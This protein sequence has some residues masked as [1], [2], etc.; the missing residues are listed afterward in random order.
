[1]R[2]GDVLMLAAG[3]VVCLVAGLA[4]GYWLGRNAATGPSFPG[5]VDQPV[6]AT[7]PRADEVKW[8]REVADQYLQA[9]GQKGLYS[10]AASAWT[11]Q[12]F[13]DRLAKSDLQDYWFTGWHIDEEKPSP[14]GDEVVFSGALKATWAASSRAP[15]ANQLASPLDLAFTVRVVKDRQS[16][17]WL[18]DWAQF[19]NGKSGDK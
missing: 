5:G 7:A 12:A 10:A 6:P 18:V 15:L 16:G 13:R 11:S 2:Q 3:V 9:A 1:M 8:A 17:R 19:D 14:Q 4:L